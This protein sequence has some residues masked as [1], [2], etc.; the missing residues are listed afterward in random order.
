MKDM[1]Q[2]LQR[3]GYTKHFEPRPS[4]PS[5]LRAP[6]T[7]IMMAFFAPDISEAA[8]AAARERVEQFSD[9][10][11]SRCADV[12]AVNV[13]WGVEDDFPMRGTGEERKGTV[14][15]AL[16]GWPSIDTHMQFRDTEAFKES[17]GLLRDMEGMVKLTMFHVKC[18]S[19]ANQT[20][21]A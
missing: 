10:A 2:V 6:V 16:I 8:K 14:L 7:E 12:Q 3:G 20:R 17:V 1:D 21:R 4:P 19:M 5:A 11:L 15:F 13:G 18:K 9:K